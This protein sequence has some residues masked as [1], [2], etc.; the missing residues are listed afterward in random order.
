MTRPSAPYALAPH[1]PSFLLF[2]VLLSINHHNN[3]I[4]ITILLFNNQQVSTFYLLL[5]LVLVIFIIYY[6][7]PMGVLCVCVCEVEDRRS[8]P[9]QS[10]G[11]EI[12][13]NLYSYAILYVLIVCCVIFNSVWLHIFVFDG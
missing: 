7:F 9:T 12:A 13:L 3:L 6:F 4:I 1:S 8:Y 10:G 2:I 5:L 11:F